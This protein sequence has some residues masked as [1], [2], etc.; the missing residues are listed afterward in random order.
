MGLSLAM[1]PLWG[2]MRREPYGTRGSRPGL[3]NFAPLGLKACIPRT[4]KTCY[5][6]GYTISPLWG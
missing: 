4:R 6:P 3:H 5:A 1:S 2:L